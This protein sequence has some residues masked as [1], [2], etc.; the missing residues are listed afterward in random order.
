MKGDYVTPEDIFL[1]IILEL[2]SAAWRLYKKDTGP[3][4]LISY[5]VEADAEQN[6]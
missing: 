3:L 2:M 5:T 1:Q 6:N 4:L